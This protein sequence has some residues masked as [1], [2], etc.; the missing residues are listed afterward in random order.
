MENDK[1]RLPRHV[2]GR[3]KIFSIP[4]IKFLLIVLPIALVILI[5]MFMHFTPVTFVFG[6]FGIVI[7]VIMFCE[8]NNRE[9][10]FDLLKVAIKYQ[11]E[12]DKYSERSC[13]NATSISKRCIR[14]QIGK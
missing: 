3:I 13:K 7:D 2:D 8:L 11:I 6:V 12:G 1:R 9:T 14:N 5:L 10:T 4:I